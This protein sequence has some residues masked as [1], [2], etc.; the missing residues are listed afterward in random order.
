MKTRLLLILGMAFFLLPNV[1]AGEELEWLTDYQQ[2]LQLS[3]QTGKPILAD[4]TGSDWCPYCKKLKSSVFVTDE[5]QQWAAD[6]VILL[7]LDFPKY[8]AQS[9]ELTMQN[10][11]LAA[12]YGIQGYP[13]VLIINS[14][15]KEIGRLGYM[16]GGPDGW[17]NMAQKILE[18]NQAG[19]P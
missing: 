1:T 5:F 16:P 4:F 14:K 9:R 6:S 7:V 10:R 18:G 11:Q 15:G 17:L 8:K 13:T 12:Q 19:G 2:A 3:K